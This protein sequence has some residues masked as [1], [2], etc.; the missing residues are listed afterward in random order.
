[1]RWPRWK[2]V[3]TVR[4]YMTGGS[5]FDKEFTEFKWKTTGTE[6]TKLTWVCPSDPMFFVDISN[7]IS[8]QRMSYRRKWILM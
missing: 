1:M 3:Y 5:M 4:F 6:I 2:K 7:I 8:L